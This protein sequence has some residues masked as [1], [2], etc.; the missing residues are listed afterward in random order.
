MALKPNRAPVPHLTEAEQCDDN[1]CTTSHLLVRGDKI[2]FVS[3][4]QAEKVGVHPLDDSKMPSDITLP[5]DFVLVHDTSGVLFDPCHMYIVRWHGGGK[6]VSDVHQ[7]DVKV[8]RD[9]FGKNLSLSVG[10]VEVP[11]GRW[12]RI[13][14]I[15][16]IRY[17]RAGKARGNYEH[18]FKPP[19]YLYSTQGGLAWKLKLPDGCIV[20]ERGFVRP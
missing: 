7:D 10:D 8:A 15:R 16:F 13:A 14:K 18:E 9:Y 11:E 6:K 19:V 17:R 3:A 1:A 5:E 20:D 4:E 12:N 2:S